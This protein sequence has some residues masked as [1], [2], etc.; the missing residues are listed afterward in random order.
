MKEPQINADERRFNPVT[1]FSEI[2]PRKERKANLLTVKKQ[3]RAR[4]T[5]RNRTNLCSLCVLV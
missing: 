3:Q 5:Q 1:K 2:I 4:R